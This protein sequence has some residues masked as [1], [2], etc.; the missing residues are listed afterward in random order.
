MHIEDNAA[1][2]ERGVKKGQLTTD[3]GMRRERSGEKGRKGLGRKDNEGDDKA[4]S[5]RIIPPEAFR[6]FIVATLPT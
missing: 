3:G 4:R 6:I 5:R 2:A 1:R